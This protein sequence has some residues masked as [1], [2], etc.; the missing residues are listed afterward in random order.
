VAVRRDHLYGLAIVLGLSLLGA[1]S[2]PMAAVTQG[3]PVVEE[4]GVE[5]RPDGA[6]FNVRLS[7]PGPSFMLRL[8][9]SPAVEAVL[10]FPGAVHRLE[11]AYRFDGGLIR[12]A[13]VETGSGDGAGV[14][15]RIALADEATVVGVEQASGVLR[16]HVGRSV[17][18]KAVPEDYRIG[19]GDKIE[20]AVFGHEDLTKLVE[21]RADG[22]INFPMIGDLPVAGKSAAD[23]DDLMTR[24]LREDFLVDPQVSVDVREYQSQWVTV[25]GEVRTPGRYVLKRNMRL[26]DLLAEAGGATKEAGSGIQ[27]TRRPAGEGEA[28]QIRVDRGTLLSQQNQS[29]NLLLRHGD[30]VSL[31]EKEVFYIRGEVTKPGPYYLENDM[32]L[33]KAITVAGGL[34]PFGNQKAIELLRTEPGGRSKKIEVNLKAIENGKAADIPLLPNDTIIVPRRIF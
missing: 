21:V 20:I 5:P 3:S 16:L 30:I 6:V 24:R 14:V 26:V 19:I 33:M 28:E 7:N 18:D 34:G 22:T 8:Q 12:A 23:V 29:A 17:V 2:D 27:I 15:L 10:E 25:M 4:I 9:T 32:T 1:A 11:D 13:R 31:S